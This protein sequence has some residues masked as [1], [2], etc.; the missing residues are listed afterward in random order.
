MILTVITHSRKIPGKYGWCNPGFA[1]LLKA[2]Y[3]QK[4]FFARSLLT[5]FNNR[6][7]EYEEFG[8]KTA[9]KTIDT[10]FFYISTD[11]DKDSLPT[12]ASFEFK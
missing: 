4:S 7:V 6:T 3:Q 9:E 10:P 11:D 1:I 5:N 2:S 8:T 12:P